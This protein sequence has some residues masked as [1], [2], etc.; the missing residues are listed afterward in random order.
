MNAV[1]ELI[2]QARAE[3]PATFTPVDSQVE[4][5]ILEKEQFK[6]VNQQ[7]EEL[8]SGWYR[9]IDETLYRLLGVPEDIQIVIGEFIDVRLALDT[10]KLAGKAL[11][12]PTKDELLEYANQIK[13]ELDEFSMG[14]VKYNVKIST[15]DDLI[16]CCINMIDA[17]SDSSET[18]PSVEAGG[19]S[20]A[21]FF[22]TLSHS[23]REQVSQWVYVQRGLRVFEGNRIYIC[24]APRRIDWLR[25]QAMVDVH[26]IISEVLNS[27][28]SSSEAKY[29]IA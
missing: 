7:L 21:E 22:S 3:G 29:A 19:R 11:R 28:R 12:K 5:L 8:R 20:K 25:T 23:L 27:K 4:E 24:K 2:D 6:R 10:K 16:I 17:D 18:L 9:E 13:S 1:D 15:S 26:D 14:V